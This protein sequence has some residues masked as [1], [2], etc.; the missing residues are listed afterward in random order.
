M[1]AIP[2]KDI[3]CAVYLAPDGTLGVACDEGVCVLTPLEVQ[4][5]I[6]LPIGKHICHDMKS[7]MHALDNLGVD[8][9][10]FAFDTALAAY[11]L[12]PSASEYPVSKLAINHLGINVDDNDAGACAQA[13]WNLHP[14]L[15]AE[16]KKQGMENLYYQIEL[17]LCP[18][19]YKMERIGVAIDKEQLQ[20]FGQM[21]SQR[22]ADCETLIFGYANG[23]FNINSTKQ[24]GEL[25]FDKLGL[26]P[27]KK[28]KTG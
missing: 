21:L 17:P 5:G 27:V 19:L 1:D 8:C 11:D 20:Q 3:Q 12:N 24:L 23:P 16:L 4:M 2:D 9:G 28:T 22:I 14:V 6:S 15:D 10:T 25:L 13:L 18:V 7:T 26:P